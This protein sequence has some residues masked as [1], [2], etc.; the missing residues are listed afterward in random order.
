ME[1]FENLVAKYE[2][3]IKAKSRFYGR[4]FSESDELSQRAYIVLWQNCQ[5]LISMDENAVK[6]F[7]STAIKNALIDMRRKERKI[8]SYDVVE[9]HVTHINDDWENSV[10]NNIHIMTVMHKLSFAEQDIVFKVY[11][12]RMTSTEIGKQLNMSPSTVRSK[13]MRANRKLKE[14]MLNIKE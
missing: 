9:N 5:K 4:D 10:V 13:L 8:T 3:F 12:M 14:F 7:L 1:L 11:F 6:A 2:K